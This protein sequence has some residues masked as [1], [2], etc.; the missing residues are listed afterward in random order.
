[1]VETLG[2]GGES[3]GPGGSDRWRAWPPPV[4]G[5]WC[6]SATT[7]LAAPLVFR[8]RHL[9]RLRVPDVGPHHRRL[10]PGGLFLVDLALS[11]SATASS[12]GPPTPDGSGQ[13]W[14]SLT[15]SW[16]VPADRDEYRIAP[17]PPRRA[18]GVQR[19]DILRQV[20]ES[21]DP[22]SPASTHRRSTAGRSVRVGA[23]LS[24][25]SCRIW[26]R[27]LDHWSGLYAGGPSQ[28]AGGDARHDHRPPL[29]RRW[30]TSRGG[31]S[32]DASAQAHPEGR[33]G[34]DPDP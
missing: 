9:A 33:R 19:R 7:W 12:S 34:R 25:P 10:R 4:V 11:A 31:G 6:S 30:P 28:T 23:S 18:C 2:R 14:C 3:A 26:A 21:R 16:R 8:R 13:P 32:P 5:R 24:T 20:A 1:M 22:P 27:V 15:P 29:R 17:P